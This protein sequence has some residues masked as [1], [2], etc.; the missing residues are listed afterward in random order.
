M[1]FHILGTGA[2]G[3]HLASRL[4]AKHHQVTLLLRSE[5]HR[6]DFHARQNTITYEREGQ[7]TQVS[8]F[9][10]ALQPTSAIGMLIVATKAHHTA[11]ALR[12][13]IPYLH[14]NSTIL[15]LQ[16]GMGVAEEVLGLWSE[17]PPRLFV[18]VNRHA[19]ER[20][21]PYSVIHHSGWN[22][23]EPA[24]VLGEFP[25]QNKV[26]STSESPMVDA[27]VAIPDLTCCIRPWEEVHARMIQKLV[28]NACINPVAALLGCKN[29]SL[30]TN[31]AAVNV[32]RKVCSEAA[33]VLDRNEDA[34]FDSVIAIAR[35]AGGNTCSMLQDIKA[36]RVTE[37]DYINGY[38]CQLA[39]SRGLD[40]HTNQ[41]L[42]DMIHAKEINQNS[43][44]Q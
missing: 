1:Q 21:Q 11:A 6:N 12:P 24:L 9:N 41:N 42:V 33:S 35:L 26:P 2:I 5:Q 18:G 28:I 10:D 17:A 38:L 15:L 43:K 25:Q 8:G 27:L 16:N 13:F 34:L 3:C 20:T 7:K 4:R 30:V 40:L 31:P 29:G 23:S 37:I 32:M 36:C 14:K 19:V 39:R 44:A 22:D